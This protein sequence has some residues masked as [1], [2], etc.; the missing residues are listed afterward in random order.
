VKGVYLASTSD[1]ISSVFFIL[2]TPSFALV[3]KKADQITVDH[4]RSPRG[5]IA[6]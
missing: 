1:Q 6:L 4:A 3:A 2:R 5:G